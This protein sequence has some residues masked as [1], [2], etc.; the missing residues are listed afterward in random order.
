MRVVLVNWWFLTGGA[1]VERTRD[2]KA[3]SGLL[4]NSGARIEQG[5]NCQDF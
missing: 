2:L 3:F 5:I 1:R 4:A